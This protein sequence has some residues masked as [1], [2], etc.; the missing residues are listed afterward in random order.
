MTTEN[1]KQDEVNHPKHYTQ[2]SIEVIEATRL[3]PGSLSNVVKYVA[4]AGLKGGKAQGLTDLKKAI[5]YLDDFGDNAAGVLW[6]R[7]PW[8]RASQ[9]ALQR[10]SSDARREPEPTRARSA[11]LDSLAHLTGCLVLGGD[12]AQHVAYVKND[13]HS[14]QDVLGKN[15]AE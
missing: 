9:K 3:L 10:L 2:Y 12:P 14:L 6:Q 11:V 13:I 15:V 4:R 1:E 8:L 7:Q 5:W